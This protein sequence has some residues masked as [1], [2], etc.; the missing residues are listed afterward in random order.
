[1]YIASY[2]P[3]KIENLA[4]TLCELDDLEG[5]IGRDERILAAAGYI[6]GA[7]LYYVFD[8]NKYSPLKRQLPPSEWAATNRH[9][10]IKIDPNVINQPG[11]RSPEALMNVVAYTTFDSPRYVAEPGERVSMCNIA[12][13]DWS[14]ALQ[15]HLPHWMGETELSANMLFRWISH[16]KAGGI[17][18]EGWQ[19]TNAAVAQLLANLGV[20]VFA[21]AKNPNPSRPG[22]VALVYPKEPMVRSWS[23]DVEPTF[24]SVSNGRR[25]GSNGV[26]GLQST[27]PRLKPTY[28]VHRIDFIVFQDA[29][30]DGDPPKYPPLNHP[31]C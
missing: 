15:V 25:W 14:R 20:P 10:P 5:Q 29:E 13:W 1:V 8:E 7:S 27:F 22:H 23:G 28:Y 18:G 3:G 16:P 6:P 17:H 9:L 2:K 19:P 4:R 12:A 11:Q 26:K 24:A 21:L 31:F 30:S